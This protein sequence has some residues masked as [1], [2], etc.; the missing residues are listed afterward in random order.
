MF[1]FSESTSG[2][3]RRFAKL[4]IAALRKGGETRI[5]RYDAQ[6]NKLLIGDNDEEVVTFLLSNAYEMYFAARGEERENVLRCYASAALACGSSPMPDRL[7]E[8][9]SHLMPCVRARGDY[10]CLAPS[11]TF[12]RPEERYWHLPLGEHLAIGL[13]YDLPDSICDVNDDELT[14]W[15]ITG[16]E[17]FAIACENLR[18]RTTRPFESPAPGVFVSP[19][20]DNYGSSRLV[21]TDMIRDLEVKGQH[22][23]IVPDRD[24]LIV[25]GSNDPAG[26]RV[27]LGLAEEAY[28]GPYRVS[29]VA[30]CLRNGQWELFEPDACHPNLEGFHVLRL[31]SI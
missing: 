2:Q 15:G 16:E 31:K 17:A 10:T 27:M 11:N 6:A 29:G 21:L 4:M 14:K 7:D 22:V 30:I 1:S 3:R 8:A 23:A 5:I 24:T 13:V 12:Q 9:R 26:L 18:L 25:T 20:D 19:W 28:S